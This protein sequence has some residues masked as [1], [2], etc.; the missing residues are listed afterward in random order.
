MRIAYK[1]IRCNATLAS[2]AHRQQS[3]TL[4]CHAGV[5][6]VP[7]TKL[8]VTMPRWRLVMHRKQS[9]TLQ[10]HAGV[11]CAPPKKLLFT[12][13]RWRPVTHRHQQDN[14]Y[15]TAC[16]SKH[17][18]NIRYANKSISRNVTRLGAATE[19]LSRNDNVFYRAFLSGMH[20]E[21]LLV[22]S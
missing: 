10:C 6:C 2:H 17:L 18:L 3:Y 16:C 1:V 5:A 21:A 4:Q 14:A 22:F 8:Y 7:P 19:R 15:V 20:R 12:V 9:C 13:P 11:T